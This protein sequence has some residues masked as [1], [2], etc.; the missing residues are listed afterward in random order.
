MTIFVVFFSTTSF[1]NIALD[2]LTPEKFSLTLAS[3]LSG[4]DSDKTKDD[5]GR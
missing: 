4:F 3:R 5:S 2:A 1:G